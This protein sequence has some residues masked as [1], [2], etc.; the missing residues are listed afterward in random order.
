MLGIGTVRYPTPFS[1]KFPVSDCWEDELCGPPYMQKFDPGDLLFNFQIKLLREVIHPPIVQQFQYADD[2]LYY[3]AIPGAK[4]RSLPG[5]MGAV[6]WAA[7]GHEALL[8]F[9]AGL[10]TV[11]VSLPGRG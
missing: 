1:G 3:A 11:L 7:P 10:K 6:G 8:L 4:V 2:I 5:S 9:Q